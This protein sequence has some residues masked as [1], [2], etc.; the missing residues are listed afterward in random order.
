MAMFR[1]RQKRPS[2]EYVQGYLA[3][4]NDAKAGR[5]Y[6]ERQGLEWATYC[7]GPLQPPA[8]RKG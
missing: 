2:M 8:P 5:Q 4:W 7:D 6:G 3:G 1:R